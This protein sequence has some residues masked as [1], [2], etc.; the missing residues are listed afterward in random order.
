[1]ELLKSRERMD[2]SCLLACLH[3]LSLIASLSYGP[4]IPWLGNGA[5]HSGPGLPIVSVILIKT[6]PTDMPIGQTNI[7]NSSLSPGILGVSS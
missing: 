6:V 3:I 1:M 2:V 5:T 4:G 7:H